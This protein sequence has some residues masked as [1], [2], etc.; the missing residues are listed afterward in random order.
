MNTIVKDVKI[1]S[2]KVTIKILSTKD[3]DVVFQTQSK[4][5]SAIKAK[6]TDAIAGSDLNFNM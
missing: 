5:W 2:P 4:N 6:E 1:S 3:G